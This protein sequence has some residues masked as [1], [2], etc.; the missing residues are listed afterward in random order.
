[1]AGLGVLVAALAVGFGIA[2]FFI[3]DEVEYYDRAIE[4]GDSTAFVQ[5]LRTDLSPSYV[6]QDA[7]LDYDVPF[8]HGASVGFVQDLRTTADLA[9]KYVGQDANLDY[10]VPFEHGPFTAFVPD[11][12]TETMWWSGEYAELD[13]P[14]VAPV[15]ADQVGTSVDAGDVVSDSEGLNV[16]NGVRSP[17]GEIDPADLKWFGDL[18]VDPADVK[19]LSNRVTSQPGEIDP[20]DLKWFGD[21]AVDPADVKF[22]NR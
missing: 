11:L 8:E 21:L 1:L 5:D 12:R 3:G 6:G 9:P 14:Y 15:A 19:F 13:P 7:N 4:H 18:A 22:L 16:T 10:D 17:P 2:N 20:A